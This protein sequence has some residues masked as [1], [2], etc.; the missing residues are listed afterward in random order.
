MTPTEAQRMANVEDRTQ[1]QILDIIVRQDDVSWKNI[2]F[3]LIETEQMDP[4]D[5]NISLIAAKFIEQLKKLQEM[6]FRISGKV[7]LASAVLLKLKAEK[8]RDEELAAL[9]RFIQTAEEPI[10][11]GLDELQDL[12]E[13]FNSGEKPQ[14]IPRTP[15]PRKRKVSVYDLVEALEQALEADARRPVHIA[16]RTLDTIDPPQHHIDISLIIREVYDRIYGHYEVER[17]DAKIYL[18]QIARSTDRKDMVMTFIPLL[19]LENARK[20]H[21]DQPEH[22]GPVAIHLLDK[23]P[24]A[25]AQETQTR[26]QEQPLPPQELQVKLAPGGKTEKIKIRTS[27]KKIARKA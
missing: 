25:Y 26:I 20:V 15:Q 3:G 24:P 16:P 5:I 2:I 17:S 13:P 23:T 12:E 22:F 7:V 11:L 10:D 1:K 18:S 19:H 27:S 8:L 9:E 14:L 21:M 6:D 4:W